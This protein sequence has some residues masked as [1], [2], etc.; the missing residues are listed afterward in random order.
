MEAG[1]FRPS[2][3]MHVLASVGGVTLFYFLIAPML[4]L[5]WD[6]DPLDPAVVAERATV[7]RDML[8]NGLAGTPAPKEATS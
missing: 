4:R 2:D 5:I 3:P 7:A 1:V 8:L 6:R